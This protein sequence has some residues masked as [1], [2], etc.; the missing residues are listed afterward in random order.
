MLDDMKM[1]QVRYTVFETAWGYAGFASGTNGITQLHLPAPSRAAAIAEFTGAVFDAG[2]MK[3]LQKMVVQYFQGKEIDFRDRP[4]VDCGPMS[5]FAIAILIECRKIRHGQIITYGELAK[6][7]GHPAAARA[8]GTVLA[9]NPIPLIVP[10]HRIIRT[11]GGL[12]GF[13][14]FGGLRMKKRLLGL[15]SRD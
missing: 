1:Q 4:P 8:A 12:G 15:E 5:S 3:E 2:L 14:G 11:D 7:A 6:R 13:S 9:R 10:C